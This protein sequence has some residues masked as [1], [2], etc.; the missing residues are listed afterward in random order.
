MNTYLPLYDDPK[1]F[2]DRFAERIALADEDRAWAAAEWRKTM[3]WTA[4]ELH[5]DFCHTPTTC[6]TCR[7]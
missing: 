2:E 3:P 5:Y 6:E 4:L 1:T 7:S